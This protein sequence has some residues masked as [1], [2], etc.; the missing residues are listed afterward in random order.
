MCGIRFHS[1]ALRETMNV[2]VAHYK[3]TCGY[4]LVSYT[5]RIVLISSVCKSFSSHA[6]PSTEF[7]CAAAGNWVSVIFYVE[8]RNRGT[9][10]SKPLICP[11]SPEGKVMGFAMLI[12]RPRQPASATGS[13]LAPNSNFINQGGFTSTFLSSRILNMREAIHGH[14]SPPDI[15]CNGLPQARAVT[16][17]KL[18]LKVSVSPAAQVQK[19]HLHPRLLLLGQIRSPHRAP[20]TTSFHHRWYP[21]GN[22]IFTMTVNTS[23]SMCVSLAIFAI[24]IAGNDRAQWKCKRTKRH[25]FAT[26]TYKRH[27][28]T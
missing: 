20:G 5:Q 26:N 19:R 3:G 23:L 11:H 24:A 10:T 14:E 28:S 15:A 17:T 22:I 7:F 4:S 1:G 2:H 16:E 25:S 21:E 6:R 13:T 12:S 18:P 8:R 9:R 27:Q